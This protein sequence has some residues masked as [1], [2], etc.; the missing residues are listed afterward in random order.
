M[1]GFISW[2]HT[3]HFRRE[4]CRRVERDVIAQRFFSYV[5]VG[6]DQITLE[7]LPGHRIGRGAGELERRWRLMSR[8]GEVRL[9]IS[10]KR[11]VICELHSCG[12]GRWRGRWLHYEKMDVLLN[13][14]SASR[15][16]GLRAKI[17]AHPFFQQ[18]TG[19]GTAY[20]LIQSYRRTVAF[21]P[22][23]KKLLAVASAGDAPL[24]FGRARGRLSDEVIFFRL[25][26]KTNGRD[27][28]AKKYSFDQEK[29][30]ELEMELYTELARLDTRAVLPVDYEQRFGLVF[31]FDEELFKGQVMHVDHAEACCSPQDGRA[32]KDFAGTVVHHPTLGSLPIGHLADFQIVSTSRGLRFIDFTIRPEHWWML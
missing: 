22:S 31:D 11:G 3:L 16:A 8:H 26:D 29:Q 24:P 2:L 19:G 21:N 18:R 30:L 10:G 6:F 15:R 13:P 5:R 27:Y 32:V 14:A 4:E 20:C 23:D 28:W 1:R 9:V 7:L 25:Q 12:E 17:R